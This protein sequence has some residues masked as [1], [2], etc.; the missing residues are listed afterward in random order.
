M[1]KLIGCIMIVGAGGYIGVLQAQNLERHFQ[2]VKK[3]YR[4]VC[5]IEIMLNCSC[6]TVGEIV[7]RLNFSDEF[8]D[9]DF[10][11]VNPSSATVREDILIKLESSQ[12]LTDFD[13]DET[14]LLKSFF[15][16]L[17]T[18]E[19][20]GQLAIVSLY[21][22]ELSLRIEKLSEQSGKK[23]RLYKAMGF[24]GGTFIAVILL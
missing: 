20:E 24:L 16:E 21:K 11:N 8:R 14:A 13:D 12:L 2:T 1:I 19:I 4:M 15:K 22:K 10:L 9:F 3:L 23:C 17:G 6:F 5:E 7:S 18:T